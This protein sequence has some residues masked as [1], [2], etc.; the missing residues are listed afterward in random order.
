[1]LIRH[2]LGCLSCQAETIRQRQVLRGFSDISEVT[3]SSPR[4]LTSDWVTIEQDS[5]E[6]AAPVDRRR[7]RSRVAIAS[8]ASIAAIGVVVVAGRRIR[9][10]A[11]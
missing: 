9:S 8:A 11:S 7:R 3:E 5:F 4:D 10:I 6:G 1:M 2:R